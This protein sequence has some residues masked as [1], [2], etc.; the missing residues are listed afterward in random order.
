MIINFC[1][2]KFNPHL[3]V[4]KDGS[5]NFTTISENCLID[6]RKPLEY[7]YNVVTAQGKDTVCE[8]IGFVIRNC[9]ILVD[10]IL[11]P[12]KGKFKSYLSIPWKEY[13]TTIVMES[14]ICDLV[15]PEG[16]LEWHGTIGL[17]TLYYAEFNNRGPGSGTSSRLR[18]PGSRV[19][20]RK[21]AWNFIVGPFLQGDT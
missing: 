17:K 18:W 16:W 2:T 15:L 6:L 10:R 9:S 13:S 19:I 8:T 3:T 12:D 5:G 20:K 1:A 11:E 4:A 7:Q 21:E 14:N